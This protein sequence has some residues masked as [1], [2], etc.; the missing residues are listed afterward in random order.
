MTCHSPPSAPMSAVSSSM[1]TSVTP[2]GSPS[3]A[4]RSMSGTQDT[5]A[6]QLNLVWD[7]ALTKKTFVG[8]YLTKLDNDKYGHYAPFLAGTNFGSSAPNPLGTNGE[9]FT[10]LG[11][12]V[13][14]WF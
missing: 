2:S 13:Q 3:S 11:F 1:P 5:G 8:L 4:L 14:F 7:Y 10:Q 9:N 12:N 6:K